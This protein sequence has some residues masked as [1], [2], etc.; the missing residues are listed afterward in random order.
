MLHG[1]TLEI[2]A[3]Y[4]T[5][6]GT[7]I[8]IKKDDESAGNEFFQAMTELLSENEKIMNDL[9]EFTKCCQAEICKRT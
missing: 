9:V 7:V 8:K 2:A 5:F 1:N 4:L 3:D 6:I